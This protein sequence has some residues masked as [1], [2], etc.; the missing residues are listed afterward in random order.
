ME[1]DI[2]SRWAIACLLVVAG[3]VCPGTKRW[4]KCYRR[5]DLL[6]P[7]IMVQD[8]VQTLLQHG[9]TEAMGA[10]RI[11]HSKGTTVDLVLVV[12]EGLVDVGG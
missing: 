10:Q 3:S 5:G 4:A 8:L 1:L 12:G 11:E 7:T 9:Y 2:E 6:G